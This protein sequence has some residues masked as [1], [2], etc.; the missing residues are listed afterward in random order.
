VIDPLPIIKILYDRRQAEKPRI[1]KRVKMFPLFEE[2]NAQ[3]CSNVFVA[4]VTVTSSGRTDFEEF[5][6]GVQTPRRSAF[7]PLWRI[8][9][10]IT[11][12]L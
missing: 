8:R 10:S 1:L 11:S 12:L 5:Q 3:G 7:T 9:T 6:L 4:D 2:R